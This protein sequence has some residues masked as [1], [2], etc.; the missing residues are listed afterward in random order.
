MISIK[1]KWTRIFCLQPL[2]CLSV[3]C[4]N[5][6]GGIVLM[7]TIQFNSEK[8]HILLDHWPGASTN[9]S[10]AGRFSSHRLVSM[11][12]FITTH[13]ILCWKF[14]AG[15][16]LVSYTC[17]TKHVGIAPPRFY[18]LLPERPV[19]VEFYVRPPL[20]TDSIVWRHLF[21]ISGPPLSFCPGPISSIVRS[22]FTVSLIT[23]VFAFEQL[24]L[25]SRISS[26]H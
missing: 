23:S 19:G 25:I 18:I 16:V 14:I 2:V 22:W 10:K 6:T 20:F 8:W 26:P 15:R 17:N 12:L 3:I 5:C 11:P 21:S 9:N 1:K 4:G 7:R 13:Y 24:L